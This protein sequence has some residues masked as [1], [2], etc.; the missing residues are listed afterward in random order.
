M[1]ALARGKNREV[2]LGWSEELDPEVGRYAGLALFGHQHGG[3][4]KRAVGD[5]RDRTAMDDQASRPG[6]AMGG[7]RRVGFELHGPPA[8]RR[9]PDAQVGVHPALGSEG[10]ELPEELLAVAHGRRIRDGRR[11][12]EY[13]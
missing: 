6:E 9:D 11:R 12:R 5:G 13:R 10:A 2:G 7:R 1:P 4:G 8:N 3:A